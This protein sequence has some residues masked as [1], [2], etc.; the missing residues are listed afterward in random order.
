M[1]VMNAFADAPSGAGWQKDVGSWRI[2]FTPESQQLACRHTETG[3]EV[4]GRLSFLAAS[5][6]GKNES[7]QIVMPRD[8]VAD[9]LGLLDTQ[10]DIQG[11]LTFA[12]SNDSLEIHAI[13]RAAQSYHGEL[14]FDASARL[15]M[16]TFACRTRPP[17]HGRV[18]QMSSGNADSL[19]N[20]SLF[21]L[22]A[23]TALRFR[24]KDVRIASVLK[25]NSQNE[26]KL[27]VTAAI[28]ET[29][30]SSIGLDITRHYYRDHYVPYYRPIDKRRCSAAP[31]GWMSWNVYFDTAGEKENLDEARIAA[32]Y[33]KQIGRASCRERV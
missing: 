22:L 19:L 12:G 15:G 27:E 1:A 31:T 2:E 18:V 21:D 5:E 25:E 16:Q 17:Q 28:A 4:S 6:A 10:G 11:Y 24:G 33:L 9:R 7:W 20:D 32:R 13:H 23:D 26:F 8:S 30:W 14:R 3:A 29:A